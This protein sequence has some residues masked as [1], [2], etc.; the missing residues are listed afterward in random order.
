MHLFLLCACTAGY[1]VNVIYILTYTHTCVCV[2]GVCVCVCGV[3]VCVCVCQSSDLAP[4]AISTVFGHLLL[5]PHVA[6]STEFVH[7]SMQ[8]GGDKEYYSG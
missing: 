1:I 5:C 2:C 6:C 4:P 3:C 8:R 7:V